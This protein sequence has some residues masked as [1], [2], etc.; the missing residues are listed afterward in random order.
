MQENL[1]KQFLEAGVHFGHQAKR[2]NP[3][4]KSF[5]FGEKGGVHIID[6]QKTARRLDAARSFLR[7][8][9][10]RGGCVL[11][12]GTKKQAQE[13]IQQEAKRCAMF[14][15][16]YR[17]LGGTLTNFQTIC[18]SIE[19]M[20]LSRHK[21]ENAEKEKMNKKELAHLN[22]DL[23]KLER[24]LCGIE[25]MQALPSALFVIDSKREEI[26]IK[27]A[28]KLGIPVVAIIDT[29]CDPDVVDYPIPAND[30]AI[31]SIKLVTS[32][33][34]DSILEG[35]QEA[36][37][38]GPKIK[39]TETQEP[40]AQEVEI[41]EKP[42]VEPKEEIVIEETVEKEVEQEAEKEVKKKIKKEKV[43]DKDAKSE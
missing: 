27:E 38:N 25:G 3:K 15:V 12:V 18:K 35:W 10:T 30:D 13:I 29:N 17:W 36:A 4:M 28:K 5:I 9:A 26:A 32:L 24:N 22:K 31:R 6:L 39:K 7:E 41:L 33:V 21:K 11:F 8:T 23:E 37:G 2:W 42:E 34:A 16:N 1:I 19:K 14:Y 20:K 40:Q 43:K